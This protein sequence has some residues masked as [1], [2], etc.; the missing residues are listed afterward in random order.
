[1]SAWAG[2]IEAAETAQSAP[3]LMAVLIALF[4]LMVSPEFP[5]WLRVASS[6]FPAAP[7]RYKVARPMVV[8]NDATW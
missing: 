1:M 5:E 3:S 8:G 6:P 4:L 7:C 2:V